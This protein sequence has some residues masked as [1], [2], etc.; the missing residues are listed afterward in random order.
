MY[1]KGKIKSTLE[2]EDEDFHFLN[3]RFQDEV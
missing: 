2:N 1:K 3:E